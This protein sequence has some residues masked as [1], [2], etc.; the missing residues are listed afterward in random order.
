MTTP[1]IEVGPSK[2]ATTA[3][4]AAALSESI[5]AAQDARGTAHLVLTGG[6]MG[7]A[8][9]VGLQHPQVGPVDWSRVHLWWGDERFV[10]SGH[11]DRNET[12]AREALLDRLG[13]DPSMVHAMPA[14]DGPDGDDV[15]AATTRYAAELAA[16]A[17]D[18]HDVP[19]FDVLM[20]GVGPDAH[21]A[22]LFPHHPAQRVTGAPTVAVED[23]PKP[24]PVRISLTYP[25]INAARQVWFMVA[26]AEKADAVQAALATGADPWDTP[27]SGAHGSQDTVWWLDAAAAARIR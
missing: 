1:R 25:A 17:A 6:S 24:P 22:S 8:S 10:P 11:P 5:R 20:L 16:H 2:D 14:T 26:G 23:S 18:G 3:A 21:I 27:A 15:A 9:L 19:A 13:L 12:E 4:I 7:G